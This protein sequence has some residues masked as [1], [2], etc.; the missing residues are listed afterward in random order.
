[1]QIAPPTSTGAFKK[2]FSPEMELKLV[3]LVKE[4]DGMFHGFTQKKFQSLAYEFAEKNNI[5]HRFNT[6]TKMAAEKWVREFKERHHLVLRTPEQVSVAR[7]SAFNRVQ[8]NRYFDNLQTVLGKT[9]FPADRIFNMDETGLSTS[10]TKAP[11]VMTP[12]GKRKVS[13]IASAER[14]VTVTAICCFSASGFYVAPAMVYPR[15]KPKPELTKKAPCGTLQL[16][17]DS[18]FSNTK[19]FVQ[20]LHHFA[21]I[22]NASKDNPVLLVLDN[23]SSHCSLEAIDFCKTH[24]ITLLSIPPHTS[25]RTQ[26]LDVVYFSSLKGSYAKKVEEWLGN[27]PGRVVTVK[28]VAKL[29]CKAYTEVSTMAKAVEGF[30]CTGIHP[31]NRNVFTERDFQAAEV[32][33]S[34]FAVAQVEQLL[35]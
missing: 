1:M 23:H 19:L 22:T 13:K 8:I 29:F 4:L 9:Q 6:V 26:P 16:C 14:G 18:G 10:P 34:K 7:A 5:P 12:K 25:H 17:S 33:K 3:C 15:K 21:Q 24:H 27:H 30:S 32:T 31:F 2:T 20:W 35:S 11:K 28:Q